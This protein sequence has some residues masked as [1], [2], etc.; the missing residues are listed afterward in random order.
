MR[1]CML[2][3]LLL[4][5]CV[6]AASQAQTDVASAM[7]EVVPR[8]CVALHRGQVCYLEARVVW[9]SAAA[10]D[11]CLHS[12]QH[13][14]APIACWQG[15]ERGSHALE[16]E[17][18]ED[19]RLELRRAGLSEAVASATIELAWVYEAPRRAR[20]SWRLF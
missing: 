6:A 5:A 17:V 7:L 14:T 18:R 1:A 9:R 13:A 20:G 8:R 4:M 15:V 16:L 11:Y 12:L 19:L 10:G 2:C 3:L